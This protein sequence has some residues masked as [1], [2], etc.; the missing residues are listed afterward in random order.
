MVGR[1]CVE[2]LDGLG[3]RSL[4]GTNLATGDKIMEH[5]EGHGNHLC[6]LGFEDAMELMKDTPEHIHNGVWRGVALWG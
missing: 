6:A 5:F 3:R 1:Y 4:C 2:L